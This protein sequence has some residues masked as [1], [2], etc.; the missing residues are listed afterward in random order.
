MKKCRPEWMRGLLNGVGGK[1]LWGERPAYAMRREFNEET[2]GFI[3]IAKWNQHCILNVRDGSVTVF[4]SVY[5]VTINMEINQDEPLQWVKVDD[6]LTAGIIPNLLFLVRMC[7]LHYFFP[8]FE[9][10]GTI[11]YQYVKHDEK[12]KKQ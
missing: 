10:I 6:F 4:S 7:Q 8:H 5:P 11:H 9:E 1:I 12:S 3:P 2:G